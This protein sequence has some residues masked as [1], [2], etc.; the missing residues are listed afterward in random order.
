MRLA[1][2]ILMGCA[3]EPTPGTRPQLDSGGGTQD[4]GEPAEALSDWACTPDDSVTWAGFTDGFFSAYCRA[5]HSATTPDRRGAPLGVDFGDRAEAMVWATRL[6]A[7]VLDEGT[8]P[9]GG[10]IVAEDR[11]RFEGW[12]C[13]QSQRVDGGGDR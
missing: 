5:C 1:L 13:A 8:M 4:S 6:K 9:R 10:G 7:R 3:A 11:E 2:L 12:L